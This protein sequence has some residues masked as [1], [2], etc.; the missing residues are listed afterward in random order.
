VKLH[1]PKARKQAGL[2]QGEPAPTVT[3]QEAA[4]WLV[5]DKEWEL[6]TQTKA[7]GIKL[8]RICPLRIIPKCCR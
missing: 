6:G 5:M 3:H 4:G 2:M 1:K 7:S 8:R